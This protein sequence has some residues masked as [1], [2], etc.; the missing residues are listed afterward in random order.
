VVKEDTRAITCF[1]PG[2]GSRADAADL[3]KP[4]AVKNPK[5]LQRTSSPEGNTW[6]FT[7]TASPQEIMGDRF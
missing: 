2:T 5:T 6:M 1:N 7:R 3:V 4:P